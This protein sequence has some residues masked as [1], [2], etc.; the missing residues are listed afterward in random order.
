MCQIKLFLFSDFE[1]AN[2][3]SDV[4][5]Q[6]QTGHDGVF[7]EQRVVLDLRN[8]H[9]EVDPAQRRALERRQPTSLFA[10]KRRSRWRIFRRDRQAER[11]HEKL[12]TRHGKREK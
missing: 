6:R 3:R 2:R 5:L 4:Q 9:Q 10:P 7:E 11:N 12:S 8:R 1:T